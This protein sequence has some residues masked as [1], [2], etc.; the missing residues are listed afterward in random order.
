MVYQTLCVVVSLGHNPTLQCGNS[1]SHILALIGCTETLAEA[2]LRLTDWQRKARMMER[3]AP[4]LMEH[5]LL[6]PDFESIDVPS[7]EIDIDADHDRKLRLAR[8]ERRFSREVTAA[9]KALDKGVVK[10]DAIFD[11]LGELN[12]EAAFRE[13]LALSSQLDI[14]ALRLEDLPGVQTVED[15]EDDEDDEADAVA[16][17]GGSERGR[18]SPSGSAGHARERT[19]SPTFSAPGVTSP[20]DPALQGIRRNTMSVQA[21]N[22]GSAAIGATRIPDSAASSKSSSGQKPGVRFAADVSP[23]HPASAARSSS[24][25]TSAGAP[26]PPPPSIWTDDPTADFAM[27]AKT[28]DWVQATQDADDRAFLESGVC[29][30]LEYPAEL[31]RSREAQRR[32]AAGLAPTSPASPSGSLTPRGSP[33]SAAG[34]IALRVKRGTSA[35]SHTQPAGLGLRRL[36]EANPA[37][38]AVDD[39]VLNLQAAG[40]G[41]TLAGRRGESPPGIVG[42]IRTALSFGTRPGLSSGRIHGPGSDDGR[43]GSL[44]RHLTSSGM[45]SANAALARL[46]AAS[47][48]LQPDEQLPSWTPVGSHAGSNLDLLESLH[49][50]DNEDEADGG[51]NAGGEAVVYSGNQ[52]H[53]F[54]DSF[55]QLWWHRHPDPAADVFGVL[56]ERGVSVLAMAATGGDGDC[57]RFLAERGPFVYLPRS[58]AA[59]AGEAVSVSGS[60]VM[61]VPPADVVGSTFGGEAGFDTVGRHVAAAVSA[62]QVRRAAAIAAAASTAAAKTAGSVGFA[63]PTDSAAGGAGMLPVHLAALLGNADAL[64]ALWSMQADLDAV[65]ARSGCTPLTLAAAGLSAWTPVRVASQDDAEEARQLQ[66]EAVEEGDVETMREMAERLRRHAFRPD[67]RA[68]QAP[69]DGSGGAGRE[70]GSPDRVV[71]PTGAREVWQVPALP[72]ADTVTVLLR[73]RF[74]AAVAARQAVS[75][76]A[77]AATEQYDALKELD[78]GIESVFDSLGGL[79]GAAGATASEVLDIQKHVSNPLGSAS[80]A[81]NGIVATTSAVAATTVGAVEGATAAVFDADSKPTHGR[82]VAHFAS[83]SAGRA[84]PTPEVL[85]LRRSDAVRM[86]TAQWRPATQAM[87]WAFAR[88]A[89]GDAA[90]SLSS[91]ATEGVDDVAALL[92]AATGASSAGALSGTG[93]Q[94]AARRAAVASGGVAAAAVVEAAAA[95]AHADHDPLGCRAEEAAAVEAAKEHAWREWSR[96]RAAAVLLRGGARLGGSDTSPLTPLQWS[97]LSGSVAVSVVLVANG[98][99][100]SGGCTG[101]GSAAWMAAHAGAAA[102][103]LMVSR[104]SDGDGQNGDVVGSARLSSVALRLSDSSDVKARSDPLL[105]VRP[106]TTDISRL[107]IVCANGPAREAPQLIPFDEPL[108]TVKEPHTAEGSPAAVAAAQHIAPGVPIRQLF[109]EDNAPDAEDGVGDWS[110]LH[111]ERGAVARRAA[112]LLTM[113]SGLPLARVS[114]ELRRQRHTQTGRSIV[115]SIAAGGMPGLAMRLFRL[116]AAYPRPEV[117]VSVRYETDGRWRVPT[118]SWPAHPRYDAASL[119]RQCWPQYWPLLPPAAGADDDAP[120]A[121]QGRGSLA[122]GRGLTAVFSSPLRKPGA[123]SHGARAAAAERAPSAERA[124]RQRRIAARKAAKAQAAASAPAKFVPPYLRIGAPPGTPL[125][126]D[127]ASLGR[128]AAPGAFAPCGR[129]SMTA[130]GLAAVA[131]FRES[132]D[133]VLKAAADRLDGAMAVAMQLCRTDVGPSAAGELGITQTSGS[134]LTRWCFSGVIDVPALTGPGPD[135]GAEDDAEDDGA[136]QASATPAGG[137]R[138]VDPAPPRRIGG[139]SF[140][141]EDGASAIDEAAARR[142]GVEAAGFADA[143]SGPGWRFW[144]RDAAGAYN[145]DRMDTAAGGRLAPGAGGGGSP[146]HTQDAEAALRWARAAFSAAPGYELARVAH[147]AAA[148][149]RPHWLWALAVLVDGIDTRVSAPPPFV[150]SEF[151]DGWREPR[152]LRVGVPL[153]TTSGFGVDSTGAVVTLARALERAPA[154]LAASTDSV[155]A[156]LWRRRVTRAALGLPEAVTPDAASAGA[157]EMGGAEVLLPESEDHVQRAV[158]MSKGASVVNPWLQADPTEEEMV[159]RTSCDEACRVQ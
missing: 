102:Q 54:E 133:A 107:A 16:S 111:G 156:A 128:P 74:Q 91:S 23:G 57:V 76:R 30:Q 117:H 27:L 51:A 94:A 125:A 36:G 31:R 109:A 150:R 2:T 82:A 5:G 78:R 19:T 24:Q 42:P 53:P 13:G 18:L 98:A 149:P 135:A 83:G 39:A 46:S 130:Q 97:I 88:R 93:A 43:A 52:W 114:L 145:H 73:K 69:A 92:S 25:S 148:A 7:E 106:N 154:R 50:M 61:E 29:P 59:D 157:D 147:S 9:R 123:A 80:D 75:A 71:L 44:Q 87:E 45:H 124:A 48:P 15:D 68:E 70:E 77:L 62:S 139:V 138:G 134:G 72:D 38:I 95:G 131:A 100:L 32:P 49:E 144:L 12:P 108:A 33:G 159:G 17:S 63:V 67:Q 90:A 116:A 66:D 41:G 1:L 21:R 118:S 119:E 81:W 89:Y 120:S 96:A 64:I 121:A 152:P 10:V 99:S 56:S 103:L 143:A 3:A 155:R 35:S 113:L 20:T 60:G 136:L 158:C 11:S 142:A 4:L 153:S 122:S 141:D 86:L 105:D 14:S 101:V 140:D 104:A 37:A 22:T 110:L 40:S 132:A 34:G 126:G 137:A 115:G 26:P 129:P 79:I 65:H 85:Y 84:T 58:P 146:P 151:A 127:E 112:A 6:K 55:V 47:P 8:F 28:I